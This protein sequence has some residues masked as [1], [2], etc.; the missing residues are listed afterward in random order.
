MGK[1]VSAIEMLKAGR[2]STSTSPDS[3]P[4]PSEPKRLNGAPGTNKAAEST[5]PLDVEA[6]STRDVSTPSDVNTQTSESVVVEVTSR[7]VAHETYQRATVFLTPAQRR[8]L[9]TTT[10]TLPVEGLSASD[11]VRLAVNRLHEDV[12]SGLALVEALTVQAHME[13]ATLSGRRNR[14]LPPRTD[15]V[16]VG[17]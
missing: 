11:I 6:P 1:S 10:K 2:R 16:A 12:D 7:L 13:A 14:G 15:S 9:K 4:P 3:A 17:E 8:W 5:K